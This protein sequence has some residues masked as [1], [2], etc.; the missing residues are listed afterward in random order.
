MKSAMKSSKIRVAILDD[1]EKF[2]HFLGTTLGKVPDINGKPVGTTR[3][4]LKTEN[5]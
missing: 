3:T 4:G 1:N 2:R 5:S